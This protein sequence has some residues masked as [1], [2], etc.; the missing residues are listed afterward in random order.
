MLFRS[1]RAAY[2]HPKVVHEDSD[3]RFWFEIG[4]APRIQLYIAAASGPTICDSLLEVRSE[5]I[6]H[7]EDTIRRI[8]TSIGPAPEDWPPDPK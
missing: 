1:I 3:R 6:P 5:T 4:D 8:G 2:V 7:R